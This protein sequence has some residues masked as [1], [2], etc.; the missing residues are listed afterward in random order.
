MSS[1]I[2]C[3]LVRHGEALAGTED[4]RRPLSDTGRRQVERL[5][6]MALERRVDVRM[7]Y[8][9]GILRAVQTAEIL[10]NHLKPSRGIAPLPGLLPE[11]DPTIVKAELDLARDPVLLVSHLPLLARLAALLASGDPERGVAELLPATMLC[12]V[13]QEPHWQLLWRVGPSVDQRGASIG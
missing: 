9:S 3:Y 7:L 4:P 11:D 5:A 10:A 1:T 13:R 8:H 12:C 2:N 6:R